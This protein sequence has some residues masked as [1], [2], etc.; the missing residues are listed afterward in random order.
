MSQFSQ[1]VVNDDKEYIL[2][3]IMR[4]LTG[5]ACIVGGTVAFLL[6]MAVEVV[7][8]A[9]ELAGNLGVTVSARDAWIGISAIAITVALG[10]DRLLSR[11]L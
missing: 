1:K 2:N 8:T 4:Y 11:R 10:L 6:V 3:S 9:L 7:P 5:G